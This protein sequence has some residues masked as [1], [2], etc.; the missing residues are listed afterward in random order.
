LLRDAQHASARSFAIFVRDFGHGLLAVGHNSLA[1]VGLAVVALLIFGA[2]RE[3]LRAEAESMAFEWLQS[4]HEERNPAPPVELAAAVAPGPVT[5]RATAANP[6]DLTQQQQAV[7]KWIARRYKVAQEPIAAL[8]QEAWA[9]G[10]HAGLD[11]TLILA[12]MAVESSFNPFAQSPVGA[13]GLMQVMTRVHDDK[14]TRFG[15]THA[16][17]DPI[18]NLRV[19]VQ[20]LKDCVARAG[21]LQQGLRHYVGAALNDGENGY[22][23]RV[24]SEQ[25]YLRRVAN[26]KGVP[27]NAPNVQQQ[28]A[29]RGLLHFSP[30]VFRYL[31]SS[32]SVEST[33]VVFASTVLSSVSR[34]FRNW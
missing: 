15:G 24:L 32:E 22:V 31:S 9:M 6:K 26:G 18:S 10:Q 1:L 21:S 28:P 13:Q 3:D 16:A 14:Y 23:G 25:D 27:V 12:V 7:A 34:L 5:T 33:R 2:D 19:G 29:A 8:V 4:R 11:P 30:V 20:V 17:F